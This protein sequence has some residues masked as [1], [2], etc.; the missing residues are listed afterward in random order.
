MKL[1]TLSLAFLLTVPVVGQDGETAVPA[2]R[3]LTPEQIS[4]HLEQFKKDILPKVLSPKDAEDPR[5]QK[6]YLATWQAITSEHYILFT[7]GP[8][9]SCKKYA[10]TLEE[11]YA[12]VKKELPFDDID[13]LLVCY[14]FKT[15]EEYYRFTTFATGWT[16]EQA[17]VTA[18]HATSAY[19]A[20]YYQSPRAATV[21]HEATHEIVGAC[22]K[23]PGVGSWFQEGLAVYFEKKAVG[24]KPAGTV[25]S[26][27]KTG[28]YY[29]LDEF[30]A[31]ESLLG[32]PK[33]N[34]HRNYAH[35][36]ALL[37]FLINTKLEPVAGKFGDLLAASRKGH[38]FARGGPA[39]VKLIKDVY[40]LSPLE[41]EE[42]WKKHNGLK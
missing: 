6:A 14:I 36:G 31:L 13:H 5:R 30:F 21:F 41:L 19:Y 25:R 38:G 18:G 24:E 17:E 33:G 39:S 8:T 27:L 15:P 35:A 42:L 11:Q 23:A 2:S 10:V 12:R 4:Q 22:L 40:G 9:T 37:D 26:D 32:D 3:D 16:Q 1:R 20:C 7:N 34:G 29:P 28:S